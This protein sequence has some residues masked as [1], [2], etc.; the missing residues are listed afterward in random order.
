MNIKP[1]YS[2]LL[3]AIRLEEPDRVP[4]AE[5]S[6]DRPV[7][8]R[9]MGRPVRDIPCDVEFWSKAGYDY[10]Y[11]RPAYEYSGVPAQLA[12]G[13]SIQ[14]EASAIEED[15]AESISVTAM[16]PI[17]DLADLEGYPWPDPATIDY[18]NLV[19][20]AVYL[21]DRMGI[22]SGVG[23]IFTRT[24]MLMGIERFSYALFDKPELVAR[25]FARIGAIQCA[26]LRR[27]VQMDKVF[28]IWYGDDLGYTEGLMV[29][30]EVYRQYL[31]PWMEELVSI[32]HSAG[33]PFIFHSDGK[34]WDIIP[35]LIAMGVNALHPIEP[36]AMD[37][38][39]V[40]ARYGHKLALFGN[41]DLGYTLVRG[42]PA[43]VRAEVRQRIKHL[44]PGGGYAVG[45]SNSIARY[46][47]VE[48]F[49]AM[50]EATFEYGAYPIRL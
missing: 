28:A 23:G 3:T 7:K 14:A 19:E 31:F 49:N 16:G 8:E 25:T 34:L 42:T 2:R 29:S 40:K 27:V 22:I 36:K 12:T 20:A 4:L 24:W 26:V 43:E 47:P 33:M 35:D 37:I 5:L 41:I 44:A 48:N 45:S 11:L 18:S 21:P 39:E 13:T 10:I 30:T 17:T 9:F 15:E 32:A 1:D 38:N 6:I 50:R 46:V